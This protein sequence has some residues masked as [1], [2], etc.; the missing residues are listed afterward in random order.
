MGMAL[1]TAAHI[2]ISNHQVIIY[3]K[4]TSPS[5]STDKACP[6]TTFNHSTEIESICITAWAQLGA[7][8]QCL[9]RVGRLD[10]LQAAGVR[11][12]LPPSGLEINLAV[13]PDNVWNE[14]I[15]K[16]N[17]W[18]NTFIFYSPSHISTWF[19]TYSLMLQSLG[20]F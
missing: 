12:S 13:H 5:V 18:F 6:R 17:Y 10:V 20:S 9:P 16:V 15:K 3:H 19:Y 1:G 4:I 8:L 2:S 14:N 11:H 7:E